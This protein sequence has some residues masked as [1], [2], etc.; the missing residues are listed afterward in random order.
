MSECKAWSQR[1][2]PSCCCW[3]TFRR[4]V[5]GQWWARNSL[6]LQSYKAS[7]AACSEW[8]LS[9]WYATTRIR[10]HDTCTLLSLQCWLII[11]H[12]AFPASKSKSPAVMQA[13]QRVQRRSSGAE[14]LMLS[15]RR[16]RLVVF[17]FCYERPSP[18]T[19][20]LKVPVCL[21]KFP[22]PTK[23]NTES[24]LCS[25]ARQG[26]SF[27]S[28]QPLEDQVQI[29]KTFALDK[30]QTITVMKGAWQ[31]GSCVCP[32]DTV[33]SSP[34]LICRSATNLANWGKMWW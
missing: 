14:H 10:I 6:A 34:A 11:E 29:S 24:F 9:F 23:L 32:G 18:Q 21:Q 27:E 16:I 28:S 8:M 33:I 3:V 2:Q 26:H 17:F 31:H 1:F 5:L 30:L 13:G 22:A 12:T 19:L 4:P 20:A 25:I 7:R 15:I